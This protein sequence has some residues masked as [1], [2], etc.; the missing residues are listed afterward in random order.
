MSNN[1]C[2]AE[3]HKTKRFSFKRKPFDAKQIRQAT[4]EHKKLPA[5]HQTPEIIHHSPAETIRHTPAETIHH[6]PAETICHTPETIH[7]TPED[8]NNYYN[9]NKPNTP[10]TYLYTNSYKIS[11][12][13]KYNILHNLLYN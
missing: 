10:N 11:Q 9:P 3:R 12:I 4:Q 1:A 8:D 5:K 6:T 2:D 13:P 7:H